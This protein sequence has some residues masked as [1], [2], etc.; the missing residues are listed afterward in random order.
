MSITQLLRQWET[1]IIPED[2]KEPWY[3]PGKPELYGSEDE[4]QSH[5]LLTKQGTREIINKITYSSIRSQ[6]PITEVILNWWIGEVQEVYEDYFLAKMV[7]VDGAQS[8]AEFDVVEVRNED[9]DR[10][11]VG[12]TFTFAVIRQDRHEGRRRLSEIEF[13]EPYRWTAQDEE[14]AIGLVHEHFPESTDL[15]N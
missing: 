6:S 4:T 8:I 13:L 11:E 10:V 3:I 1:A 12:A 2:A 9:Q 14:R 5:R 7:D 15:N